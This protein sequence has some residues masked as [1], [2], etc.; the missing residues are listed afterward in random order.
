MT[1]PDSSNSPSA[2]IPPPPRHPP[3]GSPWSA[4]WQDQTR[5]VEPVTDRL[6]RLVSGLPDWEPA[7]PG[8]ILVRRPGRRADT[9]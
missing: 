8:E 3:A 6:R 1:V 4:P 7:P 5:R 9:P 2:A